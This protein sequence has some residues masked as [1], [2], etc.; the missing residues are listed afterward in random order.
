MRSTIE[1]KLK[2]EKAKNGMRTYIDLL[3]SLPIPS[4]AHPHFLTPINPI[5]PQFPSLINPNNPIY[6]LLF[7]RR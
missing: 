5:S 3:D 2:E 7:L 1:A 4:N 6:N